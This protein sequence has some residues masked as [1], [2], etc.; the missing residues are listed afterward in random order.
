[1]EII[2]VDFNLNNRKLLITALSVVKY[3]TENLDR[4]CETVKKM[5]L[6]RTNPYLTITKQ[7]ENT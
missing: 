6:R 5:P 1:M 4:T 7:H 3:T 2:V